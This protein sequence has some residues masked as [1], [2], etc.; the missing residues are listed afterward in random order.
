MRTLFGGKGSASISDLCRFA[1]GAFLDVRNITGS[2]KNAFL[3]AKNTLGSLQA[4]ARVASRAAGEAFGG[5]R[6]AMRK[7]SGE[8]SS[9]ST[10][11]LCRF[12]LDAF[13]DINKH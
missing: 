10:S 3:G 11:D 8:K 5:P 9:A 12:A 13:L 7:N 2:L 6:R 1:L 4:A